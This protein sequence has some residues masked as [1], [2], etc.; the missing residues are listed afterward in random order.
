MSNKMGKGNPVPS[1]EQKKRLKQIEKELEE[2]RKLVR[3]KK[4]DK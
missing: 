2:V 1:D 4:G 3:K